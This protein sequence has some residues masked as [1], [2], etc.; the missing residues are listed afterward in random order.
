MPSAPADYAVSAAPVP[1]SP[2][3]APT[4]CGFT[5]SEL[6]FLCAL[7]AGDDA[8][9]KAAIGRGMASLMVDA[10]NEKLFDELGDAAIEFDGD[11]PALV[12]DYR[13]DIEALLG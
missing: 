8:A 10:V 12:D 7:L 9:A 11:R 3:A 1:L 6:A 4:P 5:P 2:A 13:P